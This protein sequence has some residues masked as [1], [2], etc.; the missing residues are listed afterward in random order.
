MKLL[1]TSVLFFCCFVVF[2]QNLTYEEALKNEIFANQIE[3]T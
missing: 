2:S 1:F 3:N